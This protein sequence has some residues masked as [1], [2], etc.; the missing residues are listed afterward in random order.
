MPHHQKD[1][2]RSDFREILAPMVKGP[3]ALTKR[4]NVRDHLR[5]GS[6]AAFGV[7]VVWA[8]LFSLIARGP[9]IWV[10]WSLVVT[11]FVS[12]I[13]LRRGASRIDRAVVAYAA[14]LGLD[15]LMTALAL[16]GMIVVLHLVQ[17]GHGLLRWFT[18]VPLLVLALGVIA[19][20]SRQRF[21]RAADRLLAQHLNRERAEW[22]A[23]YYRGNP[24]G[25]PGSGR[26]GCITRL[27]FVIGPVIGLSLDEIFGRD[28][29]I[30]ILALLLF[31]LSLMLIRYVLNDV[32]LCLFLSRLERE[33]GRPI[34]L[35]P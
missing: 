27:L 20:D 13:V 34:F 26:G 23:Y 2:V 4:R 14:L 19:M 6:L 35:R 3:E 11:F 32:A 21:T 15:I 16:S 12:H 7:G 18:V 1:R 9:A 8:V 28:V 22:D 17:L 5:V 24:S 30:E 29:A 31:G 25:M 10:M 33:I